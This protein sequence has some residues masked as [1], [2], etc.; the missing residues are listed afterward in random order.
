MSSAAVMLII[1]ACLIMPAVLSF[2]N[3]L[4]IFREY[5]SRTL[6][7]IMWIL[8]P[9]LG[10][11]ET[12][13]FMSFMDVQLDQ[14]WSEQ[15]VNSQLH[16]P[17]WTGGWLTL[18]LVC[19]IGILG[20]A[21]LTACDVNKT[22]PL[23][24]VL[25]MAAMYLL[26]AVQVLW[27]L[28]VMNHVE[29]MAPCLVLPM[30]LFFIGITIIRQKI[31][32]WNEADT[33]A[34]PDFGKNRWIRAMNRRLMQAEKW[35]LWAFAFALP[36]LGI[37]LLL[38]ILMGQEP[39]A[40]IKAWTNTTD[41]TL[42]RQT[43]P[44]NIYFDEHYLCTAAAGGHRKIVKP[45]RMGVRHGHKVVV[46]RQLMIANAFENVLEERTPAAHCRIRSFYDRYGFPVA[47]LIRKNR[48]ACDL[49]YLAMKPAEWLFLAVLYLVDVHPEN[50][51]AMQYLPRQKEQAKKKAE[52][53]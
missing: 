14:V 29:N 13:I 38:L 37:I 16:Q 20:A 43:G 27:S 9:V 30:N 31:K 35:P 39:D 36:L 32:E 44:Q 53:K 7:Y 19:L 52:K 4:G 2:Y 41:W 51:I 49:V 5:K 47:D 48:A 8:T 18:G 11:L 46:N 26:L 17:V 42:S 45:L 12:V 10:T 34:R 1:L 28:Q 3:F 21:L 6:K 23:V 50:R 24:S 33:H 15:L 25:C 22:P 40:L